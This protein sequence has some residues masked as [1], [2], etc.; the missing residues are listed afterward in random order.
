MCI[1]LENFLLLKRVCT[2]DL[3]GERLS[4]LKGRDCRWNAQQWGEGTCRAHLLQED[5][6][7]SEGWGSIPQSKLCP[8]IVPVWKNYRDG[9]G[10]EPEEKKVQWQA[11]SGIQIKGRPKAWHYYWGYG[12]LTKMDLLWL[13]SKRSNKQLKETDVGTQPMDRSRWPLLLN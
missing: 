6:T 2:R 12:A 13:S 5:R 1:F 11:Q 7:S 4:W 10:E 9:N 8:I 3:G